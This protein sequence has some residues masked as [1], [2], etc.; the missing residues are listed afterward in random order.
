MMFFKWLLLL[1]F[2]IALKLIGLA[3]APFFSLFVSKDGNLPSLLYWFS[4]PDSN[5]FGY[6][7]D[8]G[9]YEQHRNQTETWLGRWWVCTLWQ[10]R[11]TSHGFS[12][13]ILGV[14]DMGKPLVTKWETDSCY[15]KVVDGVGFDFKGSIKYPGINYR[16]RWRLGWKLHQD[17]NYPAQYVF[18]ISP[19]MSL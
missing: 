18:S 5:M 15:L 16:F 13:F 11:N 12:V 14:Y 1:P 8:R 7:G 2:D 17:L 10:W 9:F 19:I 6:L 3:F 4:T